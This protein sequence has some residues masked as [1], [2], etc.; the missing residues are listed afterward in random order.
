MFGVDPER[1]GR[2]EPEEI[3]ALRRIFRMQLAVLWSVIIHLGVVIAIL[4]VPF[5]GREATSPAPLPDDAIQV[6]L[7]PPPQSE[8]PPPEESFRMPPPPA[9]S[10]RHRMTAPDV[11]A[12]RAPDSARPM[13]E[14]RSRGREDERP[15]GGAP[16]GDRPRVEPGAPR[17]GTGGEGE[18]ARDADM[19]TSPD[20]GTRIREFA[21]ALRGAVEEQTAGPRGGGSGAGGIDLSSVPPTGFGFGNL[22]FESRDFDWSSYG[23]AVYWAIWRAWHN[24]MLISVGN[25]ERWAAERGDWTLDDNDRIR[26][27]ISRSGQ[28]VDVVVETPSGC[29]PLDASAVDALREVVLPPLPEDFPREEETV[30]ARFIANVNIRGMR[31][32]LTWLKERGYF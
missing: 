25:F 27:R 7:A 24:R 22:E 30:H 31:S 12:S 20:M 6:T 10:S 18:A 17:G 16:G 26:F 29:R 32:G 13:D 2:V 5:P 9:A 4:L 14:A 15:I 8:P 21:D 23:R 11:R 3:A 19:P 1:S 28:I